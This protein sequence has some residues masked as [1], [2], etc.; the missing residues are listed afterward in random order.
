MCWVQ[1]VEL[2]M[3]RL[4]AEIATFSSR[5]VSAFNVKEC[6]LYTRDYNILCICGVSVGL[7]LQRHHA[8]EFHP[9]EIIFYIT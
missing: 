4:T 1:N 5:I 9:Q 7:M 8:G 2:H 3:M 6:R